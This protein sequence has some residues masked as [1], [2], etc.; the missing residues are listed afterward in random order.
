MTRVFSLQKY[1]K[2]TRYANLAKTQIYEKIGQPHQNV[3]GNDSSQRM[4][5][6]ARHDGALREGV[7]ED[8]QW[9]ATAHPHP[10]SPL[11]WR[12]HPER[13]EGST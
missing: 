3:K 6:Y 4:S 2:K 11:W 1:K 8:E 7:D 12:C 9:L 5:R 13:S 10:F